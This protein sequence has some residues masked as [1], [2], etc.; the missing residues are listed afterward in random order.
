[1]VV[2]ALDEI[3]P[4]SV[5][6]Q[7]LHKPGVN[8]A[9]GCIGESIKIVGISGIRDTCFDQNREQQYNKQTFCALDGDWRQR[10]NHVE[11]QA[12]QA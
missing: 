8:L 7:R 5:D 11:Y 10:R 4:H 12:G 1:M 9:L 2:A 3:D 6:A